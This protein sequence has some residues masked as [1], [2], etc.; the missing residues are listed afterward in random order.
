MSV[1]NW[2]PLVPIS[3]KDCGVDCET[4]QGYSYKLFDDKREKLLFSRI[5]LKVLK[6]FFKSRCYF[7]CKR[8]ASYQIS[9]T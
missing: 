5:T 9:E 6:M 7:N 3:R 4:E 2:P 1:V 8:A